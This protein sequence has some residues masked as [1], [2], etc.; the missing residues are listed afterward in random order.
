MY[1]V[2]KDIYSKEENQSINGFIENNQ[3]WHNNKNLKKYIFG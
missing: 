2:D 3:L 1:G